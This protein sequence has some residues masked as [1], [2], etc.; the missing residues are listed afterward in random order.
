M[1]SSI[2]ITIMER[3]SFMKQAP[4]LWSWAELDDLAAKAGIKTKQK[5]KG[6]RV[7]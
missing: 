2:G 1:R 3:E 6:Q 5:E 7:G 4:A